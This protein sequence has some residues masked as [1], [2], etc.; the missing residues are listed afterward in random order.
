MNSQRDEGATAPTAAVDYQSA[1]EISAGITQI[2]RPDLQRR[3]VVVLG[4]HRSGTSALARVLNI[5]GC[6]A[7]KTLLKEDESNAAGYW[8]S[9]PIAQF[10]DRVLDAGGSTWH[11]W[12]RFGVGWDKSPVYQSFLT[13]ACALLASEFGTSPLILLKD[14]RIT[15][16]FSF[17]RSVFEAYDISPHCIVTLRNPVEVAASLAKRNNFST[18]KSLLIWLRYTLDAERLS[19][20]H[21]RAFVTYDGLLQDFRNVPERLEGPLGIR[22]P[23]R[24]ERALAEIAGFL[25]GDLRHHKATDDRFPMLPLAP[26]VEQVYE[27][28]R[29]WAKEG[30]TDEGREILDR[31]YHELAL[32]EQPFSAAI[33]EMDSGLQKLSAAANNALAIRRASEIESATATR[34]KEQELSDLRRQL[35]ETAAELEK[36][37]AELASSRDIER[38]LQAEKEALTVSGDEINK[39]LLTLQD[40]FKKAQ[41]VSEQALAARFEEIAKLTKAYIQ[42]ESEAN[43]V[44]RALYDA[45]LTVL[46][47]PKSLKL[48]RAFRAKVQGRLLKK[49]GLFHPEWYLNAYPD[50]RDAAVNPEVHFIRHGLAEGRAPLAGLATVAAERRGNM[51][52][53]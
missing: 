10:N 29:T 39:R 38:K 53:N 1:E 37:T 18:L 22:W 13:E 40:E 20:G 50:V 32:I 15:P 35:S 21:P 27:T 3:V 33:R 23:R 14:P 34:L 25:T 44:R 2:S 36:R 17:W 47:L 6:A 4:M 28:L 43:L 30:E 48:P 45:V 19:R 24:S 9:L 16:L 41:Q 49:V 52:D 8:E 7:P 11:D 31:I 46:S 26:W 12:Q 5:L 42:L 51:G